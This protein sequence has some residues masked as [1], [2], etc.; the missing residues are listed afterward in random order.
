MKTAFN[1]FKEV[2]FHPSV[3]WYKLPNSDVRVNRY[4]APANE[5]HEKALRQT[6]YKTAYRDSIHTIRYVHEPLE[7]E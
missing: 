4:P 7:L 5:P 2:F 6:D 3:R 1:R